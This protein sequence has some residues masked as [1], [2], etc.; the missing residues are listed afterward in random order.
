MRAKEDLRSFRAILMV[1]QSVWVV[2]ESCPAFALLPCSPILTIFP[3]EGHA[4][5]NSQMVFK[6]ESVTT[7]STQLW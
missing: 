6:L 1:L 4:Q 5:N 2:C 7:L 3:C